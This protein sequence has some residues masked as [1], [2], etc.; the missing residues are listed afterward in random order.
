MHNLNATHLSVDPE[1]GTLAAC[2]VVALQCDAGGADQ[3]DGAEPRVAHLASTVP[4]ARRQH[5]KDKV[6]G[7]HVVAVP[8]AYAWEQ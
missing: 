3:V 7:D 8:E 4:R 1:A 6:V 5:L 2:H